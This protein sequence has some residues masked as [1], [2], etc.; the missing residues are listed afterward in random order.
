ME[1]NKLTLCQTFTALAK[2]NTTILLG[3]KLSKGVVGI[4]VIFVDIL[5]FDVL[6]TSFRGVALYFDSN[7]HESDENTTL[8]E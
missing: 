4:L 7:I 1:K 5:S 6:E 2:C 3:S 8:P